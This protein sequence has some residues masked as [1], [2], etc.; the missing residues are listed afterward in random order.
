M[1]ELQEN[2]IK[3][4]AIVEQKKQATDKLL[5]FVGQETAIADEQKAIA[6]GEEE[7]CSQIAS[8]VTSFQVGSCMKVSYMHIQIR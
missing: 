4:M 7:K 5:E 2:L 1:A 6:M 8:E 3:D